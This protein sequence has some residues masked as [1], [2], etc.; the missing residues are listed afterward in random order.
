MLF[1][2]EL[3][4]KTTR[5][6]YTNMVLDGIIKSTISMDKYPGHVMVG[7]PHL[8]WWPYWWNSK[9]LINDVQVSEKTWNCQMKK[10]KKTYTNIV[11]DGIIKSTYLKDIY[12]GHVMDGYPPLYDGCIDGTNRLNVKCFINKSLYNR[13]LIKTIFIKPLTCFVTLK[14]GYAKHI[15]FGYLLTAP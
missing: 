6:T 5:N 15:T 3:I 7:Y 9:S 1:H 8:I 10:M 11:I 13:F 12:P 2:M 14:Q 4:S